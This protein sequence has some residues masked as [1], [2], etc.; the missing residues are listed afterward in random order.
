MK[1]QILLQLKNDPDVTGADNPSDDAL[2]EQN[3]G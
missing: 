2:A 1:E 3:M